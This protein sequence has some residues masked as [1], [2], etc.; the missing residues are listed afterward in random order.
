MRYLLAILSVTAL[1]V[2]V[3]AATPR[4]FEGTCGTTQFRVSAVNNGHP[5]DNTYTLSAVTGSGV[6][7]LFKGEDGGWF[8]AAC[9]ATKN[10]KPILAFQSYCGGS[11]CVEGK[12]G[13]IE[14]ASLKF[15]L[16]PSSKNVE[17]HKE[18]SAL[19][20]SSAPHLVNY[21]KAF[22]CGE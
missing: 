9:V 18:L 1:S 19:L 15:L 21:K 11:A 20:G 13:A 14:P 4:V 3:H 16:R 22:C 2:S 6:R 5:L 7:E 10:G 17:N 8:H 12:Y